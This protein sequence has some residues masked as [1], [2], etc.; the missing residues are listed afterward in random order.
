MTTEETVGDPLTVILDVSGTRRFSD[1]LAEITTAEGRNTAGIPETTGLS[2]ASDGIREHAGIFAALGLQEGCR[3]PQTF[4]HTVLN[5]KSTVL[6]IRDLSTVV[7][8]ALVERVV[9]SASPVVV[10]GI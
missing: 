4:L 6:N 1:V 8:A 5:L 3:V 9:P 2:E 10:A 7:E